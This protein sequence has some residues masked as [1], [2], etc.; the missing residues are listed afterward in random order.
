MKGKLVK[1]FKEMGYRTVNG[2]KV[3][4]YT[5]YEL[6][7]FYTLMQRGELIRK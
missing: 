3:E 1:M 6:S 2:K 5:M 4:L 7:G